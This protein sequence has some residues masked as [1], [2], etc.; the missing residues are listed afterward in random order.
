MKRSSTS[1]V[2]VCV[3]L[4]PS[5]LSHAERFLFLH[6]GVRDNVTPV[7]PIDRRINRL[8]Y[9][10]EHL[11]RWAGPMVVVI[12]CHLSE[13]QTVLDFICH[14]HLPSRLTLLVYVVSDDST[15]FPIN[16]LRNIGIQ[17]VYTT[18]YIVMDMDMWPIQSLF[19][20]MQRLPSSVL[21][22]PKSAI[23]VPL[24]F[25]RL[26]LILPNCGSLDSCFDL[27][28]MT[29]CVDSRDLQLFP[30]SLSDL[31]Q[32]LNR[33]VCTFNRGKLKTHVRMLFYCEL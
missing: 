1:M 32:C 22:D 6:L 25:F 29:S 13:E 18:H 27:Y 31:Y 15:I 7:A 11:W 26:D 10:D 9:I 30:E 24:L 8:Q 5:S 21:S 28:R 4:I 14:R 16:R 17:S 3:L 23:I 2:C 33:S 20:E 19:E 12:Y